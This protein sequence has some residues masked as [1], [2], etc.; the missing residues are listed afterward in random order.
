M[1]EVPPQDAVGLDESPDYTLLPVS[2]PGQPLQFFVNT[3]RAPLD[4]RQVRQALMYAVNRPAIVRTVFKEYSLPAYGPL[5]RPTFG[6]DP[7]VE[8]MYAYDAEQAAALLQEAGWTDSDGD[9]IRDRDGEPLRLEAILMGWGY[10]PEVGQMI[11]DRLKRVGVEVESREMTFSNALGEVAEGD[12][13]LVPYLFSS[14]DP[15]IIR[16]TFHSSNVEGGF[17]WSKFSD[18]QLDAWLEAGKREM[19]E[20]ARRQIYAEI[21]QVIMEE[22]IIL[23]I[24]DYVNLNGV[25][26]DV[27]NLRYDRQGW[28]PWLYDVYVED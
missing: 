14:S 4:N 16:S 23:P 1:G 8:G 28:F 17:N 6:Y 22:V 20:S 10:I 21:Q 15:D 5:T 24:R 11:Q 25:R 9:G 26:A 27:R 12:Y 13:D 2:I 7:E 3:Q 18:P 19:D